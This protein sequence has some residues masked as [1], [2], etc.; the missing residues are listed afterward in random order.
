MVAQVFQQLLAVL[1]AFEVVL[2]QH[3]VEG[4]QA[5]VLDRVV[6]TAG[7]VDRVTPH[8]FSMLWMLAR[9]PACGSIIRADSPASSFILYPSS[10]CEAAGSG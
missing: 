7:V 1:A 10:N 5:E 4:L 9:M 3:H 2:A 6:G 8:W